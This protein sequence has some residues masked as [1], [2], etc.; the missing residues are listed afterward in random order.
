M[1][2]LSSRIID[3]LA[4]C[5][6]RRRSMFAR[7]SPRRFTSSRRV[8]VVYTS[9]RKRRR[10]GAFFGDPV[11][12]TMTLQ[13]PAGARAQTLEVTYISQRPHISDRRAFIHPRVCI[14]VKDNCF[15]LSFSTSFSS[16]R[17]N[18]HR[19]DIVEDSC[20]VYRITGI[21]SNRIRLRA[22]LRTIASS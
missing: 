22:F 5:A 4:L 10:D 17:S 7:D 11:T 20:Y 1:S 12:T 6:S 16:S 8:R 14:F 21:S 19:C 18:L 15:F 2:R 3:A 9:T 13:P